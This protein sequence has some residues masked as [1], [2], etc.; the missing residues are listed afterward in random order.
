MIEDNNIIDLHGV[1]H[2][3]VPRMLDSFIWKQMQK[4]TNNVQ[5][6]TGNSERMKQIVIECLKE[7]NLN[8]TNSL[9]NNGTL[10]VDLI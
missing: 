1:K 4:Q 7:Y 2:N 3:D 5:I 9:I 6:I 8:C 10:S